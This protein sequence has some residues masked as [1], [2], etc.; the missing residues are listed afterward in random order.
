MHWLDRFCLYESFGTK[1]LEMELRLKSYDVL[2][3]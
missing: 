1:T 2:K 3:F